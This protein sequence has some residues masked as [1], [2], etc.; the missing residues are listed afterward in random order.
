MKPENTTFDSVSKLRN[1]STQRT[2]KQSLQSA[3][4]VVNL[5]NR[6][7]EKQQAL[8]QTPKQ[9]YSQC[10]LLNYDESPSYR[11][12]GNYIEKLTQ[13]RAKLKEILNMHPKSYWDTSQP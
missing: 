9:A 10:N 8:E 6:A 1:K 3:L 5:Q 2:Q 13:E 11:S 4:S 7:N 12:G